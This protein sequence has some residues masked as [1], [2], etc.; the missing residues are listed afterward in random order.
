MKIRTLNVNRFSGMKQPKKEKGVWVWHTD[1]LDE[2]KDCPKAV[3]II[4]SVKNFLGEEPD[5][6]VV[7]Q[8]I[9][10]CGKWDEVKHCLWQNNK[11]R[12]LYKNFRQAFPEEQYN[13]SQPGKIA[14]SCTLA[15]WNKG[16]WKEQKDISDVFHKG[17]ASNKVSA[18]IHIET[19]LKLLGIHAPKDMSFLYNVRKYAGKYKEE[20]LIIIGDFNIATNEWRLKEMEEDR[21]FLERR[22]WLL[23][24][25]NKIEYSIVSD[26]ERPTNLINS[27][28]IDH[29][30]VSP[31]LAKK[32][33]ADVKDDLELSDHAVIIADIDIKE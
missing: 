14:Y 7:L 24:D 21:E 2:L 16:R 13:L 3:S 12:R 28:T 4:E 30:L 25:M 29:V 22:R 23:E 20:M 17:T 33:S 9:P 32:T 6:V 15:I 27:E 18:L 1:R 11:E 19:N 26:T 5:G 8:E 10:Y 31:A